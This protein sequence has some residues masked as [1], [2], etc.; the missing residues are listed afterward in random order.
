MLQPLQWFI[1]IRLS[2][3]LCIFSSI[4]LFEFACI[5]Q[6]EKEKKRKKKR[7]KGGGG[8]A[9]GGRESLA[10]RDSDEISL[11]LVLIPLFFFFTRDIFDSVFPYWLKI[12]CT[13]YIMIIKTVAV[14]FSW[15]QEVTYFWIPVIFWTRALGVVLFTLAFPE[16]FFDLCPRSDAK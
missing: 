2:V 16:S 11:A 7:K 13:G 3:C 10:F 9:W 14:F 15:Y 1:F 4:D 5:A 12:S 8:G 6:K